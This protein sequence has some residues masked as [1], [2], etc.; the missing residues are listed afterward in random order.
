M[1]LYVLNSEAPKY[2]KQI[3]FETK[4]E[5]GIRI[6]IVGLSHFHQW[7]E[8]QDKVFKKIW[9][10]NCTLYQIDLI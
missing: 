6:T 5:M 8:Q 2:L 1:S 3:L 7:V 4:E 9:D 10:L